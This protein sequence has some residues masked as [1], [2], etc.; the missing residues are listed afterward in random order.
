MSKI[1]IIITAA[2]MVGV[3]MAMLM[4]FQP[5]LKGAWA[6]VKTVIAREEIAI[7]EKEKKRRELAEL[8]IAS[9]KEELKKIRSKEIRIPENRKEVISVFKDLGYN[10]VSS[11]C[12]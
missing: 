1:W 4:I 12:P 3:S 11:N 7:L 5:S 10:P 8:K 2:V 9:L 6:V